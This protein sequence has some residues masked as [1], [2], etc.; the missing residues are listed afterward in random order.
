MANG[1]GKRSVSDK[2]TMAIVAERLE[3]LT[4]EFRE[5]KDDDKSF[6]G[7]LEAMLVGHITEDNARFRSA[8]DM[9]QRYHQENI[10]RFSSIEKLL[11]EK[12]ASIETWQARMIAYVIG[13]TFVAGLAWTLVGFYL[14]LQWGH[15][16]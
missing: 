8:E 10:T 9:I 12:I 4:R 11:A 5:K 14:Q 1:N 3:T 7:K 13:G 2:V 15:N 6:G 16:K